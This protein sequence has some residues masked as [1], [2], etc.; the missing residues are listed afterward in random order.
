MSSG[1]MI[2]LIFEAVDKSEQQFIHKHCLS[3]MLV[4]IPNT[5][6]CSLIY[7]LSSCDYDML[8]MIEQC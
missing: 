1:K 5:T 6:A 7:L 4:S 8:T 2:K 3:K